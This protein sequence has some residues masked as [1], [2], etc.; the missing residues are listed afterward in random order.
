[1]DERPLKGKVELLYEFEGYNELAFWAK[2][3]LDEEQFRG[4]VEEEYGYVFP[5][6]RVIHSYA[7]NVP[8]GRDMPGQMIVQLE[9]EP[10]HGAY[11]IT[12]V[13]LIC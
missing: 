3:H 13:D 5:I 10:G 4:E 7:R 8:L 9:V 2:G 11:P 6:K 12:Y 1:M